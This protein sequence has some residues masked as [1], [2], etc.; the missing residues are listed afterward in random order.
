MIQY[1]AEMSLKKKKARRELQ[2]S[3]DTLS[4][5]FN[6]DENVSAFFVKQ[7]FL[8]RIIWLATETNV[9]SDGILS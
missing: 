3:S 8:L 7:L 6:S 5:Y 1:P 4:S 9:F 2:A